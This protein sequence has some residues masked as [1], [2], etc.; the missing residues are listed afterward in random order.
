MKKA[1]LL[2][3]LALVCGASLGVMIGSGFLVS[4][5]GPIRVAASTPTLDR[6]NRFSTP[7]PSEQPLDTADDAPLLERAD[8]VL[9]LLKAADYP[10]LSDLVHPQKGVTL[11]PYSTVD[12][13]C[14]MVLYPRQVA[15]LSEDR[16]AHLWGV[17]DGSGAPIRMT[18]P[19]YFQRYVFNADYTT[20]P[21]VGI[22]TVGISGNALENVSDAYPEGRF[23]EYC[24]P[25]IDPKLEGFDWCSLKLV[26]EVWDNNWYLVGLIHGE[27]TV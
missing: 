17:T 4:T 21:Q 19:Q 13:S 12:L 25:G 18:G 6:L 15:H 16:V 5:R 9:A 23:V 10:T 24:F 11:T 20:A 22:D 3:V 8:Q 14:D 26:F 27:W 2:A 7:A 1:L